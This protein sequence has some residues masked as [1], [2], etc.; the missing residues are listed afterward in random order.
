MFVVIVTVSVESTC[1][2]EFEAGITANRLASLRDE[3]G[4]LRFDVL[5]SADDPTRFTLYEVYR[6]EDAFF[7]DHRATGHYT[8][9]NTVVER[10]VRA[11]TNAY[12]TPLSDTAFDASPS[13]LVVG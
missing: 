2:E 6:D 7:T 8:A 1:L 13:E 9:W 3:P 4:C 5:R 11:K 12:F 10:T